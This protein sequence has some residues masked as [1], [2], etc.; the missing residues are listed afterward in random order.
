MD[1]KLSH[2]KMIQGIVNRLSNNSFLLK[3]WSVVLISGLFAL[4][5]NDT[6]ILF[7][8]LAYFPVIAFWLLD[9]YFLHQEKLFR[10]LYDHVRCMDIKDI[11]FSMDVTNL[12]DNVDSYWQVVFSKTL[13]VF[14]LTL[15]GAIIAVMVIV[16]LT[17]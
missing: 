12:Q 17:S 8:Y 2:L 9:G 15:I 13:L 16:L 14:H 3:G 6:N 11:D 10:E 4:A 1:E 5:A 7:I